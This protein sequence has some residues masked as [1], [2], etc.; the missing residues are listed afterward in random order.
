MTRDRESILDILDAIASITGY[1]SGLSREEFDNDLM[2]QDAVIRRFEVIGEAA[3]RV[4]QVFR[5]SHDNI[6]W[7]EM[8]GI[9]D[10]VIHGYDTVDTDV[11]WDTIQNDLSDLKSKLLQIPRD[12]Q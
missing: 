6:P 11:V 5:D 9:R 3:K 1:V 10:R 12:D 2:R 7:N 8:A 4:S